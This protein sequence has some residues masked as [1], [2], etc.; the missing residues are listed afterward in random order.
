MFIFRK[1]A[2]PFDKAFDACGIISIFNWGARFAYN[3]PELNLRAEYTL[4][5]GQIGRP[6]FIGNG[7]NCQRSVPK[8]D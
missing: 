7:E 3:G 1:N 6:I 5:D 4:F 8:N 2:L